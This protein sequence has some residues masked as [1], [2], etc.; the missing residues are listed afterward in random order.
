MPNRC[1]R[2]R[3]E[4]GRILADRLSAYAGRPDVV[5]LALPR[6]GVPVAFEV[7]RSLDVPLD[8]FLVRKLGVPQH[9]EL[10]MGAIASGGTEVLLPDVIRYFQLAPHEV[11]DVAR[12]ELAELKRR[13][14]A[15]R[16]QRPPLAVQGRTVILVDDGLATGA[17]MRAAVQALG[18]LLPA[19]VVIAVPVAARETCDELRTLVAEVVCVH[20]PEPFRAV[21]VWYADFTQVTDEQVRALLEATSA[22]PTTPSGLRARGEADTAL[23]RRVQVSAGEA[24]LEGDLVLPPAPRGVIL[25]AHGSGSSRF[26]ERNRYVAGV[27]RDHDFATLLL[28]LLTP[29]EE[30]LDARTHQL[31]FDVPLLAERLVAAVRWLLE[32]RATRDLPL[33]L[34]GASTGAGAALIAAAERPEDVTVVVS[35]GGRPDLA[36]GALP[37]V[38][39]P[40]LLIVGGRDTAVLEL[41]R[42]ALRQLRC[43]AELEIVPGATH[44]F[45][46]RGALPRV[47]QL[48][49]GWFDRHGH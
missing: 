40:T 33:G 11:E 41:N 14:R 46:E 35:R 31:R 13:E 1:F 19:R 38:R 44:L 16:G 5:V 43:E 25:F 20:T 30:A 10:A 8:V 34:F 3:S 4:A 27:L 17:S 26:S 42:G 45:E 22:A 29:E 24:R 49:A 47:A 2:D 23:E 21:G 9:E 15:F 7:A 36:A 28:D 48:A 18:E 6:G 39:A 12:R 37:H 32:D